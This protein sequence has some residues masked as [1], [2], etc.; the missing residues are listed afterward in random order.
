MQ[1]EAGRESALTRESLRVPHSTNHTRRKALDSALASLTAA[2]S[3]LTRPIRPGEGRKRRQ[4]RR[5]Q[6]RGKDFGCLPVPAPSRSPAKK[7]NAEVST[8]RSPNNSRGPGQRLCLRGSLQAP[9]A[10]K[11]VEMKFNKFRGTVAMPSWRK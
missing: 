8:R 4:H 10:N 6:T 5:S 2:R 9:T 1:P 3:C 11:L 7:G